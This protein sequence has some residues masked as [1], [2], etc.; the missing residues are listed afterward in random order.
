MRIG[1][2]SWE[3]PPD[4][5]LGGIATYVHELAH[6]LSAL[7]HQVVVLARALERDEVQ[8]DGPVLVYRI[9]PWGDPSAWPLL[10]RLNRV[11]QG[12]RLAVLRRLLMIVRRHRLQVLEV[13]EIRAEAL[14]YSLLPLHL[15]L[16]VKLH[17]PTRLLDELAGRRPD[18][19]R[20][21]E[22]RCESWQL[23]RATLVTSCSAALIERCRG[24]L[25][26]PEQIEV[27]PNP[28]R[29]PA[30]PVEE[31]Q[32]APQIVFVGRLEWRKGAQ[33]L[34]EVV[35]RVLAVHPQARFRLLGPDSAFEGG[36]SLAAHIR[37]RLPA[38]A[39]AAVDFAG[40]Q[41]R[42]AVLA[43]LAQRPIGLF[44]SLWENFPYACL[45]AMASGCAVVASCRGGMAEM[46]E[47][48]RSGAAVEPQPEA[49]AAALC[50]LLADP[51]RR[52]AWGE[53]ARQRVRDCFSAP[54]VARA[55][56]DVYA[57]AIARQRGPA[58]RG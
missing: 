38:S 43:N 48:G 58:W 12:H 33:L 22:Y 37:Q 49:L 31:P 8:T 45:E 2:I 16:V 3:Y 41:P 47:H 10:W 23:R 40:A 53:A 7:G 24:W 35:P 56:L 14:A 9:R 21:L 27:V 5:A 29:L 30:A 26:D 4:T 28:I 34:A 42:E 19:P 15:P 39:R 20:R 1:L 13:P 51:A 46:V 54:A 18:L 55:S 52:R 32:P 6:G 11:W 44:P 57:R 50:G 25:P 17:T 36:P